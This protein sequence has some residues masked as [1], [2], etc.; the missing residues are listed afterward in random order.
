MKIILFGASGSGT[1]TLGKA[2][3][4]QTNFK[5]LDADDYYW[6]PTPIPYT[7]KVPLEERNKK[8]KTD[9][10]KNKNVLVS[11]SLVSWGKEWERA[12]DLAIFLYLDHQIRMERL[13]QREVARYGEILQTD[14]ER[15]THYKAF[16]AWAAQ[17]DNPNFQGRSLRVHQEWMQKLDGKLLKLVG[18]LELQTK[19]DRVIAAM[20]K[21]D[22]NV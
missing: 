17:Y 15:R 2:L 16:I 18:T 19:V 13:Q 1:T 3:A 7:E 14:R 22:S 21:L 5:H 12:F 11:G 20:Q 6:R 9:F 8:M 10:L 4:Q